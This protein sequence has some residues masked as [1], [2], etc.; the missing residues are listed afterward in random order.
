MYEIWVV[1]KIDKSESEF[2]HQV[3]ATIAGAENAARTIL[4]LNGFDTRDVVR[5]FG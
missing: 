2:F 4:K 1:S 3:D 5:G